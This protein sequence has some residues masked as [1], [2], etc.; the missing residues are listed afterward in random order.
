MPLKITFDDSAKN[1]ILDA[2]GKTSD[3][4]GYVVDKKDEETRVKDQQGKEIHISEFGGVR[5]G[6]RVFFKDDTDS[7]IDLVDNYA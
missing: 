4:E 5:K 7:V 3:S 2:F 1:F 6:S